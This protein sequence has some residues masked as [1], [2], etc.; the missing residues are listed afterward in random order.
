MKQKIKEIILAVMNGR[1]D[2]DEA[3]FKILESVKKEVIKI[4][5][6]HRIEKEPLCEQNTLLT[7]IAEKIKN[8]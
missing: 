2:S 7:L 8:L 5:E 3:T 1:L 6:S 4:I